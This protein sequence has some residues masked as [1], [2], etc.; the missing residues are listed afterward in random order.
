MARALTQYAALE[1]AFAILRPRRAGAFAILTLAVCLTAIP[2]AKAAAQCS[3][4][5]AELTAVENSVEVKRAGE[6]AW[7]G[8]STG[9]VLC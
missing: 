7:H 8:A 4:W 1:V 2:L 6:A 3:G 5:Q 9:T